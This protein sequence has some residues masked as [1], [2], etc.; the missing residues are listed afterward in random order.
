VHAF[1]IDWDNTSGTNKGHFASFDSRGWIVTRPPAPGL[2]TQNLQLT[3]GALGRACLYHVKSAISAS[4]ASGTTVVAHGRRAWAPTVGSVVI[5]AYLRPQH[6]RMLSDRRLDEKCDRMSRSI[7][8]SRVGNDDGRPAAEDARGTRDR[9]ARA[10][11]GIDMMSNALK[12]YQWT[13]RPRSRAGGGGLRRVTAEAAFD[14]VVV[15][16]FVP[17]HAGESLEHPTT[18]PIHSGGTGT[19]KLKQ[20]APLLRG[21]DLQLTLA[22]LLPI[23]R[24]GAPQCRTRIDRMRGMA[25]RV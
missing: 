8:P 20:R 9:R 3:A 25:G 1:G 5:Q 18:G 24:S 14:V 4:S 23:D 6:A 15:Q 12:L 2:T 22:K 7:T 10:A 17:Q 21:F 19:V 13:L 16:L 11:M